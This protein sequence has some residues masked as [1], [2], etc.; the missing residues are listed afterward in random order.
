MD[1][2]GNVVGARREDEAR[3]ELGDQV[4]V[5]VMVEI[6][7]N[8]TTK[9]DKDQQIYLASIPKRFYE[10]LGFLLLMLCFTF[11]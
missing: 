6:K 10:G 7:L 5:E 2:G 11:T 1:K 3:I 8:K 4:G 9:L